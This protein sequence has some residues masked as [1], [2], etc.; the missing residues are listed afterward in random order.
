[1]KFK[2]VLIIG[3][4]GFLGS[5]LMNHLSTDSL[6]IH[7]VN[8]SLF[9]LSEVIKPEFADFMIQEKFQYV[10]ICAAITDI[11]KCF[12]EQTLSNQIN[13][14]GTQRLL[15]LIKQNQAIPVFFSSDYVFSGKSS[16]YEEN[17]ARN[18][19]TIYGHQKLSTENFIE[20]NFDQFLIFRTS[21][22]MSK[23]SHPKNILYPL[24]CDLVSGK[25]SRWFEDQLLNPVFVEDIAKVLKLAFMENLKGTFHLGTRR[26]YTR[27]EIGRFLASS[28]GYDTQLIES[29][30]MRDIL[31]SERRPTNNTLNCE[32]IEK[33]VGFSFCELE[34]S[35]SDLSRLIPII[36]T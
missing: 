33:A 30:R 14:V 31:F 27:A 22:L 23:T 15:D 3:E 20:N 29:I 5:S 26:I 24:I 18:P 12:K 35:L 4:T 25:S 17:D 21:K 32:K 19:T 6:N 11:E 8:R 2:K 36:Q 34:N 28:L 1:M 13:I 16:P 7:F 9:D 10:V